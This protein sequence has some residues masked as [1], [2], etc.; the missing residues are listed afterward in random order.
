M[1]RS[2]RMVHAWGSQWNRSDVASAAKPWYVHFAFR[3]IEDGKL[4]SMNDLVNVYEPALNDLNAALGYKD[5][6]IRWR[7][8][9]FQTSWY[10]VREAPGTAFDYNNYNITLLVDTLFG[11]SVIL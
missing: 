7:D 3:A 10:G 9:V 5:R 2:G 1:V 11:K 8:L 6:N 4:Q